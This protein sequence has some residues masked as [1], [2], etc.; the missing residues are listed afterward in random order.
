MWMVVDVRPPNAAAAR[1]SRK[2]RVAVRIGGPPHLWTKDLRGK[3]GAGYLVV[4][5]ERPLADGMPLLELLRLQVA[6]DGAE[7][8]DDARR[9]AA[10]DE[11][12]EPDHDR[13]DPLRLLSHDDVA[14]AAGHE[15][16]EDHHDDRVFRGRR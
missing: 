7:D 8:A 16:V 15:Q 10:C 1:A 5:E 12:D 6:V 11:A 9:D 13:H 4:A 2:A 14:D 3:V